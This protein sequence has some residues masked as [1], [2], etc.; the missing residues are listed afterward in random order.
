[1]LRSF[2]NRLCHACSRQKKKS[3]TTGFRSEIA[4]SNMPR[5]PQHCRDQAIG[6][7]QGGVSMRQVARHFGCSRMTIYRLQ[8]RYRDTGRTQ[9][10]PRSG[11]P[12]V[13]TPRQD[14]RIRM[15]HL[16][17][18]FR[19]AT[20]TANET[21]GRANNRISAQTVRR[22]LREYGIRPYRPYIGL[23]L[24]DRRRRNRR[25]WGRNHSGRGWQ[26]GTWRRV[27]FSD[28]SRFQLYRADGR[29]RVYRRIGER[30][31]ACNVNQVDRFGGG[32]V[33]VWGAIRFGWRSQLLIIDGNLTANRYLDTVLTN[34]VVPYVQQH[35]NTIFM[36]DNAR[37]HVARLC[38]D[39]LAANNVQVLDWPPYSPDLNPIEHLWDHLDRRIRARNP[40]PVNHAQLR[41]AL[42]EEWHRFP[43]Y[44][45]N[46]L[47]TSVPRRIAEMCRAHGG[48]TR[49]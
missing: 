34:Q 28:E 41:Q 19:T 43:Q 1:M 10:R 47:I 46:A 33:M 23:V 29:Q 2:V 27:M 15:L 38:Q 39:Y 49:Y 30:F 26:M 25:I 18:R 37:P 16:R 3:P 20:T 44:R 36:H 31:A 17:D 8:M 40:A 21:P 35:N 11:Q 5:L 24:N 6:M 12:R 14:R 22:R 4:R 9:D 7:M 42:I 45:I 13:T 48:H 32:S